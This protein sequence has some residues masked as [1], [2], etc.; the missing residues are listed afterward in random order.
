MI[1][2]RGFVDAHVG[3]DSDDDIRI[4]IEEWSLRVSCPKPVLAH[5]ALAGLHQSHI[6]PCNE[7]HHPEKNVHTQGDIH[8][9]LFIDEL[10]DLG[11]ERIALGAARHRHGHDA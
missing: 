6:L 2:R 10:D 3:D 5:L 1:T 7:C 4:E 8:Q 11:E 9:D